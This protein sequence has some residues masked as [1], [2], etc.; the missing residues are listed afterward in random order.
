[1][2]LDSKDREL[3]NLIQTAFPI[4]PTPYAELGRALGMSEDEVLARLARLKEGKIIRR[5]GGI[6]D[7]RRLGYKGTL[8]A[9]RVPAERVD[10]VAEVVNSYLEVTHNYLR[11]HAYNMWFT[12]LALSEERLQEILKEIKTRT[13]IREIMTLPARKIYK[14]EVKFNVSEVQDADGRD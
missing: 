10:E 12:A 3:L 6:F 2:R 13:G 5:L 14:I 11:D 8:C 7:S 1:M 9:M 4:S